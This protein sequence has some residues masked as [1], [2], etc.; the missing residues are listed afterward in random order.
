MM[1]ARL[2]KYTEDEGFTLLEMLVAVAILALL[3]VPISASIS[4][5]LSTWSD[6]YETSERQEKVFMARARLADWLRSAYPL[7]ASRRSF[8]AENLMLGS[9]GRLEFSTNI[10]P[11]HQRDGLFRIQMEF[12]EGRLLVRTQPDFSYVDDTE[13]WDETIL[14]EGIDTFNTSYMHGVAANGTPDWETEWGGTVD[15]AHLPKAIKIELNL[16]DQNLAW[17]ELIVPLVVDERSYCHFL[18]N[19]RL[20]Q[21]GA[22]IK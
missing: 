22:S 21:P 15:T 13:A 20:C 7:D 12:Q 11:D 17:P 1:R 19:E 8:Q 14:L 2:P 9:E 10:H 4:I 18:P 6:V 5:G 3:T 16:E